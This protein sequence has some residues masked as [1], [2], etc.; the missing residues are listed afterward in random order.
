MSTLHFYMSMESDYPGGKRRCRPRHAYRSATRAAQANP[1]GEVHTLFIGRKS[2]SHL[3][4][5]YGMPYTWKG[6]LDANQHTALCIIAERVF[7]R[8]R[9]NWN[10]LVEEEKTR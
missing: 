3:G 9:Y 10:R 7:N 6:P 2:M 4:R 5:E 8:D 1:L